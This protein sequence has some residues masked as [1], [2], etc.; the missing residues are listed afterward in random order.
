MVEF[1]RVLAVL[2]RLRDEARESCEEYRQAHRLTGSESDFNN[3]ILESAKGNALDGAILA[4]YAEKA[5]NL[6][7]TP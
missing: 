7:T 5:A 6:L 2:F 3:C 4:L 1:E